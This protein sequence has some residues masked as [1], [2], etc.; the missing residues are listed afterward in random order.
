MGTWRFVRAEHRL[1]GP[2]DVTAL[3]RW[4][5]EIPGKERTIVTVTLVGTLALRD[6]ARLDELLA[7]ER[8]R[9]AA[10]EE[11]DRH[12]DE[13]RG[14][15]TAGGADAEAA[16]DALALLVRLAGRTA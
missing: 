2:D 13:L 15:L 8:D 4:F 9:F 6:R 3:E 11:W 10:I 1:D 5:Q 16:A 14:A 7:R 12:T